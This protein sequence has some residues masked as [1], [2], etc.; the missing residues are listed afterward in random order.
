MLCLTYIGLTFLKQTPHTLERSNNLNTF[1]HNFKKYF[2]TE[3][4]NYQDFLNQFSIFNHKHPH[5]S[6]HILIFEPHDSLLL[7]NHHANTSFYK[8][9]LYKPA[10]SKSVCF[11]R[12]LCQYSLG[13]EYFQYSHQHYWQIFLFI[14][15]SVILL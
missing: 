2:L 6:L 12:K 10:N 4:N 9:V 14:F 3:F 15:I 7:R 8:H 13:Q 11:N 5:F 1:K